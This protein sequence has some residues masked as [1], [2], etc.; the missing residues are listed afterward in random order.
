[1]SLV[2]PQVD[3][4]DNIGGQG[5]SSRKPVRIA[6]VT[7]GVLATSFA[8]G[9]T[10]DGVVAATG[11]RILLKNQTTQIQNGVYIVQSSGAP[12]RATDYD[13]GDAVAGSF[14]YVQEGA[15]NGGTGW[16]CTNSFG[17]DIIGTNNI[18]FKL[19]SGDASGGGTSTDNAIVRWDGTSGTKIQ[20]SAVIIDDSNN[21]TGIQYLQFSDITAPVN[22]SAGQGR[23]YKK[24]GSSSIW[25]RP[26]AA[27]PELDLTLQGTVTSV[28][29]VAPGIFTVSG[30]PITSSGNLTFTS[31]AQNANTVYAGPTSGGSAVPTFRA[32]TAGDISGVAVTSFQTSLAGLA[33]AVATNG[34][35]T[36]GGTLG[37]TSGGTGTITAPTAGQLLVGTSGGTYTPFTVTVGTG[38]STTTGSGTFQI[39]N[40]GVTSAVAGTGISVSGATGAVTITNNG[41]ISWSGGTTGLTPA[42]ASTGAVVL[43]GTL[44]AVNGGTGFSSY[45]VGDILYAATTSTF[46][47]LADV[48]AGSYLRSGGVNTAPL[49]STLTLPN[50]ATTGDL[51]FAN[52]T[53]AI[54][55]LADVATGN[56]LLSGG[57]GVAPLWGKINLTTAVTGILPTANGGTGVSTAAN[58]QLLIGNGSG[59]ALATI[60]VGTGGI[61]ITNGAGTITLDNTLTGANLG[62][63]AAVFSAKSG[64]T[65]NFRSVVAGTGVS[66]TQNAND[67][68][69]ANTGVTS[70][71]AGTGISVSGAT[72]AVTFT[73]TGVI[74]WSGGTTG[75]TPASA[76]T[77]AVTLGGTLLVTSG[78][79]GLA[80]IGSNGLLFGNGTAAVGV[81]AAGTTGQVLVGTTGSAPSWSALSGLAVTSLTGTAN[82][83]AVSASTGAVTLSTPATFVAPGTI[84]DTTGMLQSTTSAIT[85]AGA[86]QG[87]A[88]VLTTSYNI[89]TTVAAGTGVRLQTPSGAGYI[90]TV[91]NRGANALNV[92]P[93]TGDQI[94][95]AA[96]NS[97][98]V[99]PVGASA[100]YQA[101]S[102]GQWYTINPPIVAGTGTT[103]SYGNGRTTI[104]A[105]GS[106]F[107]L[108]TLTPQV[109]TLAV[110]TAGTSFNIASAGSTH[111][112]NLPS[113][114]ETNTGVI[115]NTV[116]TVKGGKTFVKDTPLVNFIGSAVASGTNVSSLTINV[117]TG[118]TTTDMLMLAFITVRNGFSRTDNSVPYTDA[119]D[120]VTPPAGW[121]LVNKT[122]NLASYPRSIFI[123]I[124]TVSGSEPANYTWGGISPGPAQSDTATGT[125]SFSTN[126]MNV[127]VVGSG[128]FTTGQVVTATGVTAGTTIT[129]FG[130]GA[131]GTGTY[132]LST[133]PGTLSARA[134]SATKPKTNFIVGSISTY[135]NVSSFNSINVLGSQ[136][137]PSSLT[138]T[139][140]TSPPVITTTNNTLLITH[141]SIASVVTSWTLN[142]GQTQ[143]AAIGTGPAGPTPPQAIGESMVQGY[144]FNVPSGT[145]P[146]YSATASNDP[147]VGLTLVVAL[148]QTSQAIITSKAATGAFSASNAGN[149]ISGTTLTV[150]GAVTGAFTL[151]MII[152]GGTIVSGT[153]I[154]AFGTGTGGTGTYTVS[155]SQT[156]TGTFAITGAGQVA[157]MYENVD[158][159]NNTLSGFDTN[160]QPFFGGSQPGSASVASNAGN[161]ITAGL[162]TVAGAVTGSLTVGM[163]ITGGTIVPNTRITAFGTGTGGTGT[164]TVTPVQTT[165][166]GAFAI[167]GIAA[168]S[169]I[170]LKTESTPLP[171]SYNVTVPSA[172]TL[173]VG[174][175]YAATLTNKVMTS[176]TNNVIARELWIDSGAGSVSSYVAAAPTTG[177]VLTATSATTMA[178]QSLV[179]QW[180]SAVGTT[181]GGGAVTIATVAT[182]TNTLYVVEAVFVGRRTNVAGT[183]A[184]YIINTTFRNIAGVLTR[185]GTQ[186]KLAQEDVG[187]WDSNVNASGTNIVFQ[188]TG[189][190]GSTINWKVEYKITVV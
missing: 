38:I 100:T 110:G 72:G 189:A 146:G 103:V 77:G 137:T 109:Q 160:G 151:G 51:L 17:T 90:T 59:F 42:I 161:N 92:Y 158:A 122:T 153:T 24:T 136:A 129:A 53:N 184:G 175:D 112:F 69:I 167:N 4:T 166:G 65:L 36:L 75:L 169:F 141:Y 86:T 94:D 32:L 123:Y 114:S 178:F 138:H 179:G 190:G 95:N 120:I 105:T 162:L 79:T 139:T 71:I 155:P 170:T 67:I 18:T 186:S 8:D 176:N 60:S 173:L 73:N 48:A 91:V 25:W 55:T 165:T 171:S 44:I 45:A 30:S 10:I 81:T 131:G 87:T 148:R 66:A 23:L 174:T 40:T 119:Q 22:P 83:V 130:T 47:K 143:S 39:N 15:V 16:L 118:S 68:T 9:Q 180:T 121:I 50:A 140:P 20:N 172:N 37:A 54:S 34:T 82:Q 29:L 106:T 128:T 57:V 5:L 164:Y 163:L 185:I 149:Q 11:D 12:V 156:T 19:I 124:K 168:Q 154:T 28:G 78:G 183:G 7:N 132:I 14:V 134:V 117:P 35:V 107:T 52:A 93:D 6:T 88:T 33:P 126:V 41:V 49:W 46:A 80:T 3:V 63:G 76:A 127:T 157:N 108:N 113:A 181:V 89:V 64:A 101:A 26:D 84:Q 115:T 2:F 150:A 159:F 182:A 1:M 21:I 147:D 56:A 43:G 70:A 13:D 99:L 125:A 85:A 144:L 74:S 97:P 145:L 116:Q 61:S 104:D 102:T 62:A 152:S 133:T 142:S 111:T 27:G 135:S 98:V 96:A 177:Q 188:V 187:A 58:G 31:N